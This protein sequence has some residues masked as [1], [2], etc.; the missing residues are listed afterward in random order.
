MPFTHMDLNKSY[1]LSLSREI[2]QGKSDADLESHGP[3]ESWW[4]VHVMK[5]YGCSD[6]ICWPEQVF[7]SVDPSREIFKKNAYGTMCIIINPLVERMLHS[8]S[9]CTKV[10]KDI[11]LIFTAVSQN[12]IEGKQG[13]RIHGPM[14]WILED[15]VPWIEHS[16]IKSFPLSHRQLQCDRVTIHKNLFTSYILNGFV[17]ILYYTTAALNAQVQT[18]NPVSRQLCCLL[19]AKY[20]WGFHLS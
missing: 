2:K 12:S 17:W 16:T 14:P 6:Q 8:S 11:L 20:C 4:H 10:K 15:G 19:P 13:W 1:S 9:R 7:W 3:R 18:D 5:F